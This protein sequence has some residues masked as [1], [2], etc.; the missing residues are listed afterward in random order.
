MKSVFRAWSLTG[1]VVFAAA[2]ALAD[3]RIAAI[4]DAAETAFNQAYA[5]NDL[6]TYFSFYAD[7]ATLMTS[8]GKQQTVKQ[9]YDEWRALIE[10]G[11]G[12]IEADA[13][14]P[15]TIRVIGDHTAIVM[16]ND[17]P[18]TYRYPTDT[19]G[20]FVT[21]TSVWTETDVWSLVG[22]EWKIVHVHY[23]DATVGA[24]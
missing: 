5:D 24:E 12:V 16:F 15:R 23:H 2:P 7:D 11:G 6:E 9:Y 4:I 17:F 3:E 1:L 14:H 10:A 8:D 21:V 22:G 20:E 13:R 19:P 18:G